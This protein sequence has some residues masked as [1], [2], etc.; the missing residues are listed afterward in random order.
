MTASAIAPA[1]VALARVFSQDDEPAESPA[2]RVH[3]CRVARYGAGVAK[4]VVGF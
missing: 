2:R 4:K 3:W 1:P